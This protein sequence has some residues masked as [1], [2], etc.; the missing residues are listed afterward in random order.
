MFSNSGVRERLHPYKNR[1]KN[2]EGL[3]GIIVRS[4]IYLKPLSL[5]TYSYITCLQCM[6]T[7]IYDHVLLYSSLFYSR[8]FHSITFHSIL[9]LV[10]IHF[11]SLLLHSVPFLYIAILFGSILVVS[12]NT[13]SGRLFR[14][15]ILPNFAVMSGYFRPVKGQILPAKGQI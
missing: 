8:L 5:Y 15:I 2:P 12:S 11:Y 1:K 9:L 10:C 14:R 3:C 7:H 4:R 6:Y 13:L